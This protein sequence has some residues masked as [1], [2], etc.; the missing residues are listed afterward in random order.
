MWLEGSLSETEGVSSSSS[1]PLSDTV[2]LNSL[3][4]IVLSPETYS[5]STS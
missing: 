5:K 2:S 1:G 3:P 4:M